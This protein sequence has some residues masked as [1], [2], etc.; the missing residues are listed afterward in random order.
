MAQNYKHLGNAGLQELLQLLKTEFGLY[1]KAEAGKGLSANDFTA[2]LLAKLNGIEEGANKYEHATHT[3]QALGLWKVQVD[4]EGHVISA[5]A[6]A[7]ED[8]TGLGIPGQDTT[9]V[10]ATQD[11]DG[12]MSSADKKKLDGVAEGAN[13]YVH[14]THTEYAEGFYKFTVDGEGHVTAATAVVKADLANLIGEATLTEAGLMSA[15]DKTKLEGIATGAQVNVI[16]EIQVNGTK[17]DPNGKAINIAVPTGSLAGKNEVSENELSAELK[18]KVNAASEGNHSHN[19]KALLDTYTQTEENLA[20]AVAKKHEHANKA[21]L[22]LIASGDK[23]KWD[24]AE[25][26]AHE[27][28]NKAELDK[29]VEGDKAKWDAAQANAEATAAAALSAAKTEL[30]GKISSGDSTTLQSA[31]DYADEKIAAQISSAYKAAGTV[32]FADLPAASAATEGYVYNISDNFTTTDDFIEGAGKKY[33]AG[34]N[35]VVVEVSEGNFSYDVLA[36]SFDGFVQEANI[37]EYTAEEVDTLW[38]SVF[39]A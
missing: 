20:D 19:N 22:D 13:K 7:K 6:V 39:T 28:A 12:L 23:A 32:A 31:K 21:E 37:S 34:T 33:M 38:N 17:V 8:I 16:E 24:A 35:V 29:I 9:Y 2:E 15:A 5:T 14:A 1:V 11:A 25:A 30:E 10:V 4:G 36:M 27:H 18:E 3:A 26:K